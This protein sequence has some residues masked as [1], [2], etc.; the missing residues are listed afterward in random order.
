MTPTA[1]GH[2]CHPRPARHPRPDWQHAA[3]ASAL[4]T[5]AAIKPLTAAGIPTTKAERVVESISQA[6]EQVVTRAD[7][8]AAL[9]GL[10]R[11]LI[12]YLAAAVLIVVAA[13]EHF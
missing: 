10:E 12:V 7:L 8:R 11:R 4:D 2:L 9:A 13:V 1:S 5:H 3:M 6:D